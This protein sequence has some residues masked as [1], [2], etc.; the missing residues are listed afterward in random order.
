[1]FAKWQTKI[2]LFSRTIFTKFV[3]DLIFL[4][5]QTCIFQGNLTHRVF[6]WI[7][8]E[9]QA[10]TH[11]ANVYQAKVYSE[12]NG[13]FIP[14]FMSLCKYYQNELQRRNSQWC[15]IAISLCRNSNKYRYFRFI[16]C[17]TTIRILVGIPSCV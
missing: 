8:V 11:S 9:M 1:M 6:L 16:V 7:F 17:L 2:L 5:K 13:M 14:C 12:K 15:K 10:A 3:A 4:N